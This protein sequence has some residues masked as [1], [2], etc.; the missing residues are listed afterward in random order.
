MN[1]LN[2]AILKAV[3]TEMKTQLMMIHIYK[4]LLKNHPKTIFKILIHCIRKKKY[5][6]IINLIHKH[7]NKI[8]KIRINY[9]YKQILI[10]K[11]NN[12]YIGKTVFLNIK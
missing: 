7:V 4:K 12:Y 1:N 10:N 11:K 8:I 5:L 3:R 9:K 2:L 6:Q